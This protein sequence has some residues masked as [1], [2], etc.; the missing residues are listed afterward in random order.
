MKSFGL[1]VEDPDLQREL[2]AAFHRVMTSGHL[3]LGPET[4][5]FEAEFAGY[6]GAAHAVG[7]ANG[8]DAISLA[9]RA[10]GIGPGDE[11]IVPSHTFAATWLAPAALGARL[12]PVEPDPRTYTLTADGVAAAVTP[13]TAAILPVSL[14]GHPVDM[15]GIMG[16][17][18]RHGLFV[19]ED[20]AQGHGAEQRGRRSGAL[21]HASAFSFYPTKN[22]G[23][24]G[25][26]GAVVTSDR[27]LAERLR[28]L[29]NYGAPRKNEH[30]ERGANSRLDEL[31]AALLRV[32]LP[33]LDAANDARRAHAAAYAEALA[34]APD[35]ILPVEADWARHVYHLYVVRCAARPTVQARLSAAD[36][37][38]LIHYPTPCHLQPAFAD[39]GFHAG[40]FPL[41]EQLAREVLSLP[42]WPGMPAA[43]T[44]EVAAAIARR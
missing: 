17:A 10:A 3:I 5:A 25:D 15:E 11:V 21:A 34:G 22:L 27:Q 32:K 4:S 30:L 19:L 24:L 16:L 43:A 6:C 39:L 41:A 28:S 40:Q 20:A 38:T 35:L 12:V 2:T 18:G 13:R 8:L 42:L 23:A 44:A 9:L 1:D 7:V 29:R 14:Y 31:Q 33:R 36:I 26:G 37:Q